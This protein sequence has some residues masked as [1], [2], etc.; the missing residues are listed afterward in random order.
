MMRV[1]TEN[2]QYHLTLTTYSKTN[3]IK[4]E[5]NISSPKSAS[6]NPFTIEETQRLEVQS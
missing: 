5:L 1:Y 4:V 6:Q 3:Q 2:G